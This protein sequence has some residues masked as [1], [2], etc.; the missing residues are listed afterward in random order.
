MGGSARSRETSVSL[1]NLTNPEQIN[2]IFLPG[3]GRFNVVQCNY[4]GLETRAFE[5]EIQIN[6]EQESRTK[7]YLNEIDP[8][9]MEY[10]VRVLDFH[11]NDQ[12]V[13]LH[14]PGLQQR[15]SIGQSLL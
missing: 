15:L 13:D 1:N 3:F 8:L 11:I 10:F 4:L 12:R 5:R 7:A 9:F 6:Q 14:H 2:T